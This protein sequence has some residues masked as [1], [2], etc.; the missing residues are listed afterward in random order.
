MIKN[1][2]NATKFEPYSPEG[3]FNV[4]CILDE[5][6]LPDVNSTLWSR[7][8]SGGFAEENQKLFYHVCLSS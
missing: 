2:L 6:L 1:L 3:T 5:C 8:H 7:P 4:K